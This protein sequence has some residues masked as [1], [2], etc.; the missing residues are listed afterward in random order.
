MAERTAHKQRIQFLEPN[1]H[2]A[3]TS[4]TVDDAR[5]QLHQQ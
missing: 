5:G 3:D 1:S 2:I 4:L